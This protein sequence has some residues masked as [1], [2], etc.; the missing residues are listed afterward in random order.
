ML[1]RVKSF[2]I[3]EMLSRDRKSIVSPYFMLCSHM[4][5]M[6]R[7]KSITWQFCRLDLEDWI[8]F[9]YS[10]S[11]LTEPSSIL[12]LI[13]C[14]VK[15][16]GRCNYGW[17]VCAESSRDHTFQKKICW[18]GGGGGSWGALVTTCDVS[19]M[20]PTTAERE[21]SIALAGKK[22]GLHWYGLLPLL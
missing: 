4:S 6:L 2:L 19:V 9:S 12:P 13:V 5:M 11:W 22:S 10:P 8:R 17:C 20:L 21:N 7:V 18:G 16:L 3:N 1:P 14:D 15:I